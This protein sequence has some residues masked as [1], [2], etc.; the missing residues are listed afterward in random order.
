MV[1]VNA[2][3]GWYHDAPAAPHLEAICRRACE[4]GG[5]GKPLLIS[6]IGAGGIPG[7]HDP[8]GQAK[9]SEERQAGILR[10]QLSAALACPRLSGVIVWQF[11]DIRVDESWF[12]SRPR[13]MNNKGLVD[14]YRRPKLAYAAVRE[15][16]RAR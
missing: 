14:E 13:S 1:S 16:F 8:L 2:Y 15:V 10:E 11:A 5:E 3:P 7:F 4:N 9:W 6:E 12:F